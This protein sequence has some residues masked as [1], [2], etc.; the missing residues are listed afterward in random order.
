MTVLNPPLSAVNSTLEHA[1]DTKCRTR[2]DAQPAMVAKVTP[3]A[4]SLNFIHHRTRLTNELA[5][6]PCRPG[7]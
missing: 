4:C 6:F 2:Y 5:D 7:Q 1:I 3:L